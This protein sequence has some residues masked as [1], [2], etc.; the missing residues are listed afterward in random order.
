MA[1]KRVAK[2]RAR[3]A[4]RA[5]KLKKAK[6]RVHGKRGRKRVTKKSQTGSLRRVWSGTAMYTKSGLTKKDLCVNKRGKILSKKKAASSKRS[7]QNIKPWLVAVNRAR[8]ELALVGFVPCK[9]GTKYYKLA[10]K[11]YDK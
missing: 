2:R 7:F 9:K 4:R 6:K 10:R 1:V 8:I 5:S 3:Q 11:Y